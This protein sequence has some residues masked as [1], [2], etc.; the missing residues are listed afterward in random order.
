MTPMCDLQFAILERK[1]FR[2]LVY[3]L[4]EGAMPLINN[5]LQTCISTHLA[6]IFLQSQETIKLNHLAK[7][8]TLHDTGSPSRP[9]QAICH[10]TGKAFADLFYEALDQ[11][12]ATDKLFTITADNASP[13]T[14]CPVNCCIAHVINL[15]AKAGI[16]SR[17]IKEESEG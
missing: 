12:K 2:S 8:K 15:A 5:T 17:D 1:L 6:R 7:Q 16:S 14:R 10:H 3:L 9:R 4:N 13:T 11:Y